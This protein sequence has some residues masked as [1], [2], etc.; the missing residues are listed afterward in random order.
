MTT[1]NIVYNETISPSMSHEEHMNFKQL[2][3]YL[4]RTI[5]NMLQQGFSR[6]NLIAKLKSLAGQ[7]MYRTNNYYICSVVDSVDYIRMSVYVSKHQMARALFEITYD[8]L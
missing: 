7:L 2:Q 6:D 4:Y 8:E 1:K 5:Y 3:L